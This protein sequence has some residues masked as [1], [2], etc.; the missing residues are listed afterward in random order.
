M[1]VFLI[2]LHLHI[3]YGFELIPEVDGESYSYLLIDSSNGGRF[4]LVS[5]EIPKKLLKSLFN[6]SFNIEQFLIDDVYEI[7]EIEYNFFER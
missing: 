4:K 2:F 5:P 7:K 6:C 3:L 1:L